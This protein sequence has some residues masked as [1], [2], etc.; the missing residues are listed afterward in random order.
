MDE[1]GKVTSGGCLCGGVRY[2]VRGPLR[3]VWACH[4]SQ[5]RRSSGNFVAATRCRTEHL[6]LVA[7]DTLAW[8]R[9]SASAERGFCRM[10]GS[11]LFWRDIGGKGISIM[12][13][14]LDAPTGLVTARHIF[15]ADKSDYYE[16]P[17]SGEK[18]LTWPD[19]PTS[20]SAGDTRKAPGAE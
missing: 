10:C 15:V 16:L 2:E 11:S 17:A 13:G 6:T 12:A 8:Y 18:H 7:Q 9:S 4:C 1:A 5:C 3:D 20:T 19:D 14:T